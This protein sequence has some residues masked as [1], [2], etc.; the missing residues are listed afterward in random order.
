MHQLVSLKPPWSVVSATSW[1]APKIGGWMTIHSFVTQRTLWRVHEISRPESL[2]QPS[3]SDLLREFPG[4]QKEALDIHPSQWLQRKPALLGNPVAAVEHRWVVRLIC[5]CVNDQSL[6]VELTIVN[7]LLTM[8]S[9]LTFTHQNTKKNMAGSRVYPLRS[10]G[11][12]SH[13]Q[14]MQRFERLFRAPQFAVATPTITTDLS[15]KHWLSMIDD[16]W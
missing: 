5:C 7:H 14:P 11:W 8:L 2:Q 15:S 13:L 4:I 10:I 1:D 12:K 16:G 3:A 9:S 6:G